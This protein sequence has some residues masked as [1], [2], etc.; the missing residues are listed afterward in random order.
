LKPVL[1]IAI[2]FSITIALVGVVAMTNTVDDTSAA[3]AEAAAKAA[4]DK[5]AADKAADKAAKWAAA[6]A[7]ASEAYLAKAQAKAAAERTAVKAA[8]DKAY[9]AYQNVIT[10]TKEQKE[11][12]IAVQEAGDWLKRD[13][14]TTKAVAERTAVKAA[15][16]AVLT[17]NQLANNAAA[18]KAYKAAQASEAAAAW[19][20]DIGNRD[21]VGWKG[22]QVPTRDYGSSTYNTPQAPTR[23]YGSSTYNTPQAPSTNY[24]SAE[25]YVPPKLDFK[26]IQTPEFKY[27]F[28]EPDRS[29][30]TDHKLDI[31]KFSP[32]PIPKYTPPPPSNNPA[33][34]FDIPNP[35]RDIV[36][37]RENPGIPSSAWN[38]P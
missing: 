1:I 6:E 10:E 12:K 2:V 31:P 15:D 21:Q 5:A 20:A 19:N 32:K 17:A 30:I 13:I 28:K 36:L 14:A 25:P 24:G 38:N 23:D 3:R 8:A 29:V 26:P 35:G 27:Q 9:K 7:A 18:D 22:V 33:K 4:A 11:R 37:S 16:K 34:Q